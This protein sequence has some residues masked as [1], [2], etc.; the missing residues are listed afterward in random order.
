M[1]SSMMK[2]TRIRRKEVI[3]I[4]LAKGRARFP[5]ATGALLI[6]YDIPKKPGRDER[7]FE[8]EDEENDLTWKEENANPLDLPWKPWKST[9]TGF[10]LMMMSS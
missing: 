3:S 6:G 2:T 10:F 9:T 5:I 4:E 7:L 1:S 8:P